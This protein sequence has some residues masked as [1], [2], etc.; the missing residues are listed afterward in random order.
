[1]E[2]V[3]ERRNYFTLLGILLALLDVMR[4]IPTRPRLGPAIESGLDRAS[5][6]ANAS[7]VSEQPLVMMAAISG[8]PSRILRG[9]GLLARLQSQLIGTQKCWVV[10][11]SSRVVM[12]ANKTCPINALPKP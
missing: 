8:H 3:F 4:R 1:M 12:K 7:P 5:L 10:S 11:E 6:L 2:L 9:I